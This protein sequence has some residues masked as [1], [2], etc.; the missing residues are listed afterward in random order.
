MNARPSRGPYRT[1]SRPAAASASAAGTTS[2]PTQQSP[3]PPSA[4][5]ISASTVRSPVPSEPSSRANGVTSARSAPSRASS[6]RSPDARAAGAELV[7]PHRHRRAHDLGRQRRPA[8]ARVRAQQPPLVIAGILQ[9]ARRGA[10]RADAGRHAVEQVA[11][12]DQVVDQPPRRRV[13]LAG[14]GRDL[15]LR[16]P[17][18]D[19]H[20]ARRGEAASV[21]RDHGHRR[22][23]PIVCAGVIELSGTGLSPD[24]VVA[25]ARD[26]AQVRLTPRR[27]RRWRRAPPS[28]TGL[29]DRPEPAYGVSTGFGSLA[30]V[31]IPVDRREEL[32]R[33]LVR[34]HAAG[35]GPPVE[36][37]V[38]RA[39]MLLRA[40]TLAMGCSGARPAVA[41][42]ILALLN[43]GHHPA[44]AGVRLAGR[45]R[46]PRPAR[47]LRA[48]AD[49][50]GR[51]DRGR[52]RR[53]RAADARAE[54]GPRADQ[55]HRRDARH[56]DPRH[57]RPRA[58]AA[59]GRHHRRDVGR[60]A[61]RHRPRVRRGPGR[62]AAPRRPGRERREPAPR[63]R[64]LADRRQPPLQRR[65]RAGRLLAALRAAGQR[66]R[67][68]HARPRR[69]GGGRRARERDRQPDG[70]ARRPRR[71]VRQLPRRPARVRAR[72]PRHRGRRGRRDRRA[73]HRPPARRRALARAAAVPHAPSRASTPA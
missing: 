20:D 51:G 44:R 58:A 10:Q 71:V 70:A 16:A 1:G 31:T 64:R 3:S 61:A 55:R 8:A 60:G 35:M 13:A 9:R 37:E 15:R 33:A 65:P 24:D 59:G 23:M 42:A 72:L 11:A 19:R 63:A 6:S 14:G 66:R 43:A 36:P 52:R 7:R 26:R 17:P 41:E 30:N 40:R 45:E 21:E 25:V 18:R 34:S 46:R 50:R 47:P 2:S 73:P 54:G 27:G 28:S 48:R 69:A 29:A 57:P 12:R 38:V 4:A 49:R 53:R 62:A 32:Q 68:R 56:A 67:A 5:P 39:M 22:S